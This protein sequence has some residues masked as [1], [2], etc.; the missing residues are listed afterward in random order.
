[1]WFRDKQGQLIPAPL[2]ERQGSEAFILGAGFSRTISQAMPLITDLVEPLDRFLTSRRGFGSATVPRLDNVELFL[3]TLAIP[4]PYL[5]PSENHHNQA[6]FLEVAQWLAHFVFERQRKA[7]A[8]T[9]PLWLDVLV[10]T[11]HA[12]RSTVVTFNYDT[13]IESAVMGIADLDP[14]D[15]GRVMPHFTYANPVRFAAGEWGGIT[16]PYHHRK[17]T[18]TLCKLHGSLS[19]WRSGSSQSEP[20]DREVWKDTFNEEGASADWND[21]A[22]RGML[23]EPM[24]VPPTFAKTDYF[25]SDLLR[26]N[27]QQARY[28]IQNA[29][30]I[31]VMGYSVPEADVQLASLLGAST[32]SQQILVVDL[33]PEAIV[34][35]ISKAALPKAGIVRSHKVETDAPIADWSTRWAADPDHLYANPPH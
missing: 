11:W 7:L 14:P 20:H 17:P 8:Q 29:A 25:E 5:T 31:V 26:I 19:W 3:S 33:S 9:I 28:G 23:G 12:R 32:H 4:Q 35:R 27:W 30:T 18:F 15:T 22:Q 34:K 16:D 13:L 1:M 24:L 21:V 2:K 10:R 6:L